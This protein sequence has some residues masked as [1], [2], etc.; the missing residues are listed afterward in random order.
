MIRA[1]VLA[2]LAAV[3]VG[4]QAQAACRH[5]EVAALV[6]DNAPGRTVGGARVARDLL[7]ASAEVTGA[8]AV[9]EGQD[10]A[11]LVQFT[12]AAAARLQA[13]TGSHIGQ[14]MAVLID[15]YPSLVTEISGPVGA[16]GIQISGDFRAQSTSLADSV[17]A[18]G[19][20]P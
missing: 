14:R 8:K 19:K 11:V 1:S 2:L 4:A 12:P 17:N 15:G 16:Q 7:V 13:Y 5:I 20:A 3:G 18:C 6:A 10:N 9:A